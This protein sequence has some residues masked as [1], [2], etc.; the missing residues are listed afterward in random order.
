MHGDFVD[1]TEVGEV[2]QGEI[3]VGV[4]GLCVLVIGSGQFKDVIFLD[5]I[6]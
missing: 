4:H 3:R 6:L 1:G 2:L 5:G